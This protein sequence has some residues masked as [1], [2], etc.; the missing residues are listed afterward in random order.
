MRI[1]TILMKYHSL[2]SVQ[3]R[4]RHGSISPLLIKWPLAK[5]RVGHLQHFVNDEILGS[6]S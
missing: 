4:G 6:C 2:L 5:A 1:Q 3:S